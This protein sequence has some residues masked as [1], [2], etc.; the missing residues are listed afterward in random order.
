[1]DKDQWVGRQKW[2]QEYSKVTIESEYLLLCR[3]ELYLSDKFKVL[4][5]KLYLYKLDL[6]IR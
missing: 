1:M 3:A 5:M 4:L 2:N 6:A